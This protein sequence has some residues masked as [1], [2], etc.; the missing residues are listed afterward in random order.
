MPAGKRTGGGREGAQ[1]PGKQRPRRQPAF[2]IR[3]RYGVREQLVESKRVTGD[4]GLAPSHPPPRIRDAAGPFWD[5][6]AADVEQRKRH[7]KTPLTPLTPCK[8]DLFWLFVD[9][10]AGEPG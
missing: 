7:E 5:T 9:L 1:T 4:C 2:P 3:F 6:D 8:A 10:V